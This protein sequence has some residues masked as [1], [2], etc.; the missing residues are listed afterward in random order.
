MMLTF[1]KNSEYHKYFQ[2]GIEKQKKRDAR[3]YEKLQV[4]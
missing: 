1:F 2:T 4:R 3:V